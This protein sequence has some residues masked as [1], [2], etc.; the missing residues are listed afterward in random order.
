MLANVAIRSDEHRL[1]AAL[2]EGPWNHSLV[3]G[4]IAWHGEMEPN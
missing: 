3:S 4:W 2:A 1:I